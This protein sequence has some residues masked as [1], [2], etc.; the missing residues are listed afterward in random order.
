MTAGCLGGITGV[1]RSGWRGGSK[2]L[3]E[4]RQATLHLLDSEMEIVYPLTELEN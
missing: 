1:F 3:E 4:D 2:E